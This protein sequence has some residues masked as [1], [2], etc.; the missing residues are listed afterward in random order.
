MEGLLPKEVS[1]P[2]VQLLERVEVAGSQFYKRLHF[3]DL[4]SRDQ[5]LALRFDDNL[6]LTFSLRK[7][8]AESLTRLF[9][10]SVRGYWDAAS[11]FA[12]L[13]LLCPY[14]SAFALRQ[15]SSPFAASD[16]HESIRKRAM[17][18]TLPE[19]YAMRM[20]EKESGVRERGGRA[21]GISKA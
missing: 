15:S 11:A 1:K 12:N 10:A 9:Y 2:P 18:A 4:L 14:S 3:T 21:Q 6:A 19:F 8:R 5:E 16:D 7:I 17:S 13:A 20:S